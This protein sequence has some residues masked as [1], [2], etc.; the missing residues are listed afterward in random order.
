M[1]PQCIGQRPHSLLYRVEVARI[2]D[3][4]CVDEQAERRRAIELR[5][6]FTLDEPPLLPEE[7]GSRQPVQRL[8]LIQSH[9]HAAPEAALALKKES[10][11]SI[12]EICAIVGIARNTYYKYTRADTQPVSPKRHANE[13]KAHQPVLHPK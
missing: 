5:L 4:D 11:H 13:P 3:D 12:R 6:I 7:E 2:P 10:T 9:E 8:P 1:S